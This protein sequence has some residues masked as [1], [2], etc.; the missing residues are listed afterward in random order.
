MTMAIRA[1]KDLYAGSIFFLF[2]AGFAWLARDYPMGRLARMG[3]AYFPTVLGVTLAVMGLLV[4]LR[5][6]LADQEA[7]AAR[8]FLRPL[9][10]VLAGVCL[11][12]ALIGPF[13]LVAS[14]GGLIF[15]SAMGGQEFRVRDSLLLWAG[16]SILSVA[17]F[18]FGLHLQFKVWPL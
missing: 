15:L 5:A 7:P 8:L 17:V 10:L 1:S 16:L 14:I 12:A 4:A 18:V 9:L 13:G 3:P 11:F 6:I 2:G